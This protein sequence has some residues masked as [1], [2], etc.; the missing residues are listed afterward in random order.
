MDKEQIISYFNTNYQLNEEQT[1]Y[2][3]THAKRFELVLKHINQSNDQQVLDIGPS[4]LSILLKEKYQNNL[5]L[6]GFA[7]LESTG[8]HLPD[9]EILK[10]NNLIVQDLN[11]WKVDKNIH[12]KYDL[13]ICAEVMEHLYS[14]PVILLQNFYNSLKSN[15]VL[16]IQTPNAVALKNRIK[17][18]FGKNPYDIPR[19]N[20]KNPG[21]F[22]EYTV[23]EL[24]D[25]T[26]KAG[27]EVQEVITDEY[28]ENASIKSKIYRSLKT[29]IP[30]SLKSGIT[31]ILKKP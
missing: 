24:A 13:I 5:T 8:G 22:R 17:L 6:L 4:F 1:A 27:F 7:D 31:I 12:L 9:I 19:E 16:M 29:I 10:Q 3:N 30:A 18:L 15:G 25:I 23:K 28:F 11:F 2:L 21:H 20:V 26:Q 14:S